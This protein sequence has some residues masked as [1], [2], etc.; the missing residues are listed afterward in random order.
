MIRLTTTTKLQLQSTGPR[1]D[2]GSRLAATL[3]NTLTMSKPVVEYS[4]GMLAPPGVCVANV[5]GWTRPPN[6]PLAS[7]CAATALALVED[8]AKMLSAVCAI[9]PAPPS[10][11]LPCAPRCIIAAGMVEDEE[12]ESA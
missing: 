8:D 12:N 4:P 9:P 2:F 6:G 5:P 1:T 10:L 3:D 11:T 7:A